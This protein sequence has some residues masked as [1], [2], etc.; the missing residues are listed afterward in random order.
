MDLK[1]I[2]A[3]LALLGSG[4][5]V[6]CDGKPSPAKE[7]DGGGKDGAGKAGGGEAEMSCAPGA[8]APGMCGGH[9]KEEP[10][11]VD[12][13]KDEPAKVDATKDAPAKAD[14]V[15]ALDPRA[16]GDGAEHEGEG[17]RA[18]TQ[19]RD[20]ATARGVTASSASSKTEARPGPAKSEMVCGAKKESAEMTC[21]AGSCGAAR[22]D[23]GEHPVEDRSE[24]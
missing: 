17:P 11:E 18:P 13:T 15:G 9:G 19:A 3:T 8:C 16:S 14:E 20:A 7:V 23:R 2:S 1:T 24:S 5:L 4:V 10:T 6:G 12:A 21:G 22:S